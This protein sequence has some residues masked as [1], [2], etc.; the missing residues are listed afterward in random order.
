MMQHH[1][2][3]RFVAIAGLGRLMQRLA[4]PRGG[5]TPALLFVTLCAALIKPV[6]LD[7]QIRLI[8]C[9]HVTRPMP[10]QLS[11]VGA[12]PCF[13]R[14]LCASGHRGRVAVRI[15]GVG[16]REMAELQLGELAATRR[17]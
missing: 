15:A 2:Q 4:Q 6:T 16:A 10:E 8:Y 12:A 7:L 17:R 5:R 11:L 13:A 3:P 1:V 14:R 9:S